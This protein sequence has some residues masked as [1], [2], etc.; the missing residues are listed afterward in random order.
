MTMNAREFVLDLV[1]NE[2]RFRLRCEIY[3][4]REE[5]TNEW[6]SPTKDRAKRWS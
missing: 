1:K 6:M 2:A 4:F 3:D 5:H